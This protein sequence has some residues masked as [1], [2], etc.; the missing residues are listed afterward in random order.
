MP[1]ELQKQI[2]CES[3]PQ[4]KQKMRNIESEKFNPIHG[5]S[6]ERNYREKRATLKI[7]N[8]FYCTCAIKKEIVTVKN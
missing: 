4:L 7:L 6:F 8:L 2:E 1:E 3:F 5:K